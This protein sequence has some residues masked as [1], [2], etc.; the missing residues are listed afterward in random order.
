MIPAARACPSPGRPR[1]GLMPAPIRAEQFSFASEAGE[2]VPGVFFKSARAER[3]AAGCH[4]SA[5]NRQQERRISCAHADVRRSRICDG[6]DRRAASWRAHRAQVRSG[7]AQYFAAM[8][9]TYRTGKGR[10]YLYDTVWDVMRLVDYLAD[11]RGRRS[12]AHRRDGHLERRHRSVS[13]GRGRSAHCRRRADHR[14][15]G[16]PVG[17]RQ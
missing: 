16:I 13:R 14:R 1:R 5:R 9:E 2:R 17:A 10:P 6:G 3:S 8:L 15:A 12:E 4:L 11:A 7:N